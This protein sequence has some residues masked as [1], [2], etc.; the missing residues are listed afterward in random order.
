MMMKA[1][2][3]ISS[4]NIHVMRTHTIS[5]RLTVPVC[6]LCTGLVLVLKKMVKLFK[7]KRSHK[8]LDSTLYQ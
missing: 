5:I 2:V 7:E 4:I 1:V 3:A 6:Q 8:L